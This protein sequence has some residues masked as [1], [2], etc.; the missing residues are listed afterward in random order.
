MATKND[1]RLDPHFVVATPGRLKD[2]IQTKVVR[3]SAFRNVVL[4]EVDQM[5]DI[6]FI[7]DITY[8]ISLLPSERQSLFF[9]ATISG[10]VNEVLKAF[11]KI[12]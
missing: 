11:V 8:F 2:F 10:R 4:D 6:G 5:V 1:M 12:R 3:M 7:N 9:S